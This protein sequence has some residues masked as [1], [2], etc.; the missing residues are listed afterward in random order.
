ML[1]KEFLN[2][3]ELLED[4]ISIEECEELIESGIIIEKDLINDLEEGYWKH[5]PEL[6]MFFNG[7]YFDYESYA[8]YKNQTEG[9]ELSKDILKDGIDLL[10][11]ILHITCKTG[12]IAYDITLI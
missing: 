6:D 4:V 7:S 3:Y 2:R 9:I 5:H 11:N 8:K 12:I 10:N 1:S